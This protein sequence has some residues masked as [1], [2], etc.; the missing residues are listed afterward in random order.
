MLAN[1]SDSLATDL[2]SV[3][4]A[5][6]SVELHWPGRLLLLVLNFVPL[7]HILLSLSLLCVPL[8]NWP[9]RLGIAIAVFYLLPP[10]IARI[11]LLLA[12]IS[13]G[14][15]ALG[16]KPF[17]LWWTLFQLQV[18]F[19]RIPAFEEIMRLLPGLYSLWLRLWGSRIGRLTY[20]SPGVMFTD[21]SFLHIGNDVVFGAGA[22][23][24]AH[25]MM[26]GKDG[27][28]QL[29]LAPVKI[30]DRALVGGYSL[31]TAGTEVAPDEATRACQLS[32][33]FS[34][35]QDG[36]RIKRTDDFE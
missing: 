16:S 27:R 34:L 21:R 3:K 4:N 7:L 35:W 18:V 19:C 24:N 26:K 31:L 12:P 10:V 13:F 11:I 32:P 28:L 5:V 8:V 23:L 30:G 6:K 36:R 33:P 29:V 2:K 14:R 20:W 1:S 22:R 25:V 9:V 17:F 15:I